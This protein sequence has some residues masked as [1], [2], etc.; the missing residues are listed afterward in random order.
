[1][2]TSR[3]RSEGEPSDRLCDDGV[4]RPIILIT[5]GSRGIGAAT[6]IGAARRGYDVCFSYATDA[7]AADRVRSDCE[8]LGA[9]VVVVQADLGSEADVL[10]L[11]TTCD[12]EL[13]TLAVL[14]NNAGVLFEQGTLT[15]F[16]AERIERVM[17]VNVVG[18]LV[19]A[20]EAARRMST[21]S[22]GQGGS[23]VNVSSKASA[24][25]SPFEYVDYAASK[26]AI[27]S[28]T[29]GLSKELAPDGIRVNAVRPGL[30]V[31]DIHAS[32]GDPGRVERLKVHI[33]QGRG[34][35][36]EEV[37]NLILWVASDEASY[38]NGAIIDVAGGR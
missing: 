34:G 24:I 28:A 17:M 18:A 4:M 6:A 31:T 14:V 20:R 1:M 13:G 9:R 38:V 27:D 29:L 12:A 8:E 32:G 16:S 36:A 3:I 25:G 23:I 7:D 37:A 35:T 22:G 19:C 21:A 11:F 15:E 30:I 5:G 26:G 10:R 33:P 2:R